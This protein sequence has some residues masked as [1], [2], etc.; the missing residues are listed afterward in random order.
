MTTTPLNEEDVIEQI[1]KRQEFNNW[2]IRKALRIPSK[3]EKKTEQYSQETTEA[4]IEYSQAVRTTIFTMGGKNLERFTALGMPGVPQGVQ[5]K[6]FSCLNAFLAARSS[7]TSK[8]KS[9]AETRDDSEDKFFVRPEPAMHEQWYHN[10]QDNY[11]HQRYYER[12]R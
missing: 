5:I 1:A 3:H 4:I 10:G 6:V 11:K 8:A 12:K 7:D 2:K 9:G